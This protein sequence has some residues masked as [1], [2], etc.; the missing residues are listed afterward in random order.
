MEVENSKLN[1]NEIETKIYKITWFNVKQLKIQLTKKQWKRKNKHFWGLPHSDNKNKNK[2]QK[3]IW[4]F[5]RNE[6]TKVA[7]FN[8][9]T[10]S[11]C[12]KPI[13]LCSFLSLPRTTLYSLLPLW[14]LTFPI[15][16]PR[17]QSLI[18]QPHNPISQKACFINGE[19]HSLKVTPRS[20]LD[21]HRSVLHFGS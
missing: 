18:P 21:C 1:F 17:N 4:F 19:L 12:F 7:T 6:E 8:A 5:H 15:S 2:A 20:V 3:K 11:K 10:L 9:L 14:D 13:N 16:S